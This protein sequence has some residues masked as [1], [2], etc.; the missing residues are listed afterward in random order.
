VTELLKIFGGNVY[1]YRD[2]SGL[3]YTR[4]DGVRVIPP[5]LLGP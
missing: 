2:E 3:A 1:H 5:D 4:E